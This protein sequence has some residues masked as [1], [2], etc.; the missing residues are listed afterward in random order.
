MS[1]PRNRENFSGISVANCIQ[2]SLNFKKK[3]CS[4]SNSQVLS[5][6]ERSTVMLYTSLRKKSSQLTL[7]NFFITQ[8]F[9]LKLF[10]V[11]KN[12][13]FSTLSILMCTV[14]SYE[15]YL[16]C[17]ETDL[18]NFLTF[19]RSLILFFFVE[20]SLGFICISQIKYITLLCFLALL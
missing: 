17:C 12:I 11:V 6:I 15:I 8:T 20:R 16:Q 1:R 14:Q 9:L 7:Y 18:Q 2:Q 10:I 5:P 13:K 3:F 4:S 19:T